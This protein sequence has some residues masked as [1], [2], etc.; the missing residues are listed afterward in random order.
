[1]S[2]GSLSSASDPSRELQ[3]STALAPRENPVSPFDAGLLDEIRRHG[4]HPFILVRVGSEGGRPGKFVVCKTQNDIAQFVDEL[5]RIPRFAESRL[6]RGI[7][8]A[9]QLEIYDA[10]EILLAWTKGADGPIET[11]YVGLPPGRALPA[12]YNYPAYGID[13]RDGPRTPVDRIRMLVDLFGAYERS[14]GNEGMRVVLMEALGFAL[15]RALGHGGDYAG[16]EDIVDRAL[17]VRPY[18]IHLKAAR[19]ALELKRD[20]RQVP[21][22]L[23]KYIGEDNGYLK[24]FVCPLPFERFDIGPNGDVLVCC[25]HWLPTS[26]GNFLRDSVDDVLNSPAAKK[27]RQ[28]VTDGSYRYC[29]H[30]ECGSMIQ[31]ILPT[32]AQMANPLARA[33]AARGDFHVDAVDHV[34]FALDQTCNLS[35]PSCRTHRIVEKMSEATDKTE[36]VEK[37]LLPLLS[38]V[39]VLHINPAGEL[40]ASK[41][42]RRILELIDDEH[43]PDLRI[44]IISNGTLFSESEWNKFPGIHNKVRSIRISIDAARKET[45]EKLRRLGKYDVFVENMRFLGRLRARRGIRQLKF[46]FTYQLDNFQEMP[47]FVEFCREM[48]ADFAIF[49]RLQN[50]GAFSDDEYRRAAVHHADHP[51]Y[52][53]FIAVIKDPI[54]RGKRVWHDF[55]YPDVENMTAEEARNRTFGLEPS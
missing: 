37:K 13:V 9:L 30:L 36:A 23:V 16:A 35:C 7:E 10:A 46:S 14:D 1:M 32:L 42:S 27:I 41:P 21:E 43:C 51:R 22:R 5:T 33:A 29:N 45:F 6:V 47:E 4:F 3:A 24:Q 12:F 15:S 11:G 18:S 26:I 38:T 28:S 49:E 44:D 31:G 39:K 8:R 25:G 40:L 50:L 54:F 48:N 17:R 34:L 53:E 52:G 2:E 20:G 55:D 19:H